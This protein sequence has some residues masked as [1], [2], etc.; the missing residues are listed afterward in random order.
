MEGALAVEGELA[1]GVEA[2]GVDG[3]HLDGAVQAVAVTGCLE[4]LEIMRDETRAGRAG[5]RLQRPAARG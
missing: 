4:V 5:R 1:V 3:R 2:V